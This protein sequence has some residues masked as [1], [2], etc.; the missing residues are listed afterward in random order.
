VVSGPSSM[1]IS[2][3]KRFLHAVFLDQERPVTASKFCLG[4]YL[5]RGFGRETSHSAKKDG[6]PAFPCVPEHGEVGALSMGRNAADR[7]GYAAAV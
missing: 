7:P 4:M 3:D 6:C 5:C 2:P 1:S